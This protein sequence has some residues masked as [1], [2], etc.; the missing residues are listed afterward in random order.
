MLGAAYLNNKKMR[1]F[2]DELM[3]SCYGTWTDSPTGLAPET[4]SW[5]D[6]TQNTTVFPA[7]MRQAVLTTGFLAQNTG[8]DLRPGKTRFL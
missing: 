1:E 7:E 6:K 5:I 4:W 3:E 2:A 8:Y